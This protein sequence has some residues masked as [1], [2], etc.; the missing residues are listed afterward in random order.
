MPSAPSARSAGGAAAAA[1]T[2]QDCGSEGSGS[3]ARVP[4][5]GHHGA[6]AFGG[7][8]RSC[9]EWRNRFA[10]SSAWPIRNTARHKADALLQPDSVDGRG[11]C[12]YAA[13]FLEEKSPRGRCGENSHSDAVGFGAPPHRTG[14]TEAQPE[15]VVHSGSC[16]LDS[17]VVLLDMGSTSIED[18]GSVANAAEQNGA[19]G[20]ARAIHDSVQKLRNQS[21]CGGEDPGECELRYRLPVGR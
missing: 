8:K 12:R 3:R 5:S 10:Y 18:A 6:A 21:R 20:A 13:P 15:D 14:R 19:G 2:S 4:A 17:I 7:R 1:K 9:G 16:M 11:R